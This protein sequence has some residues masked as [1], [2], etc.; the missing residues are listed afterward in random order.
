MGLNKDAVIYEV[1]DGTPGEGEA[2][3]ALGPVYRNTLAKDGFAKFDGVNNLWQMFH[4][5]VEKYGDKE[6]FGWRPTDGNQAQPFKWLT[7]KQ[8]AEQ[9]AKIGGGLVK[10]GCSQKG[11]CAVFSAN[12]PEWAI[13]VQV[14]SYR[15]LSWLARLLLLKFGCSLAARDQAY[16][17]K[18]YWRMHSPS[19][20]ADGVSHLTCHISAQLRCTFSSLEFASTLFAACAAIDRLCYVLEAK[21]MLFRTA[22]LQSAGISNR[23]SV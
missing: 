16:C 10:K 13:L 3:P 6:C 2:K 23:S 20:G 14:I 17:V 9:A 15:L 8:A 4:K 5:S 12:C 19:L 7:Y 11:R 18:D 22:G 1:S 21:L